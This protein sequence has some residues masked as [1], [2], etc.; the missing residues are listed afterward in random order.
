MVERK[1]KDNNHASVLSHD[2]MVC[3]YSRCSDMA[4]NA[5]LTEL[6]NAVFSLMQKL[7]EE[8]GICL[9]PLL[10]QPGMS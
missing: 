7:H 10:F 6:S 4:K 2:E 9:K 8:K 5:G 3:M 1:V